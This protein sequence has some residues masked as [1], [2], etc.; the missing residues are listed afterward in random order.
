M[1]DFGVFKWAFLGSIGVEI[2]K[3][4][5]DVRSSV[6][7]KPPPVY[8]RWYFWPLRILLAVIAGA[9]AVA[10]GPNTPWVAIHVGASVPAFL[11]LISENPPNRSA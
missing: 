3:I 1:S 4:L 11:R 5:D 8:H 9:I 10:E 7:G 2:V 6:D